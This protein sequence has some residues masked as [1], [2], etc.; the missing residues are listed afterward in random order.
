ML[1]LLVYVNKTVSCSVIFDTS[2]VTLETFCHETLDTQVND[3]L[4][5]P[6]KFTRMVNNK[7][8]V[9]GVK[10]ER[11]FKLK[12]CIE[13]SDKGESVCLL[14]LQRYKHAGRRTAQCPG[15]KYLQEMMSRSHQL[16]KLRFLDSPYCLKCLRQSARQLHPNPVQQPEQERSRSLAQLKLKRVQDAKNIPRILERQS[17]RPL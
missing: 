2:E 9:V 6:Y 13:E 8:T 5:I 4:N 3:V 17:R 15:A 14:G 1:D 16:R 12:Q 11:I 7:C 10:Q